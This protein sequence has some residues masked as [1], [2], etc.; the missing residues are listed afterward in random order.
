M[1]LRCPRLCGVPVWGTALPS[2]I[3]TSLEVL[4]RDAIAAALIIE[5]IDLGYVGNLA[6]IFSKLTAPTAANYQRMISTT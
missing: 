2:Q 5:R 3:L 4:L 6:R 1:R